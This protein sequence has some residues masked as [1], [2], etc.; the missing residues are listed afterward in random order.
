MADDLERVVR[1]PWHEVRRKVSGSADTP[2]HAHLRA[3]G[4]RSAEFAPSQ[5]S[6]AR[7]P[8]LGLARSSASR[9]G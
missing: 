5:I 1:R 3:H 7:N 2:L 8:S 9:P 4:H 6:S